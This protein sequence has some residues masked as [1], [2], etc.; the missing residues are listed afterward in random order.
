MEKILGTKICK[1]CTVKFPI[2]EKDRE[3]YELMQ[4][5]SPTLCY[6]CRTQRRLS[7]RN[8]RFLYHRKCELTGKEIISSFSLDKP[9]PVYEN[10]AWWSDEYDPVKYGRDFDFNRPFFEQFFLLRDSVPRLARQQQKPMWNSDYCNCA[11]QNKNCYLVFSTNRCEDCY[12]G[13][14]VN[15][16]KNCIDSKNTTRCELCYDCT[17]CYDCYDL[18]YSQDCVNCKSSNFLRDCI[19]CMD[20]FACSNLHNKQ[21][22]IFN[23]KKTKEE[24]ENFIKNTDLGS[25]KTVKEGKET[26]QKFLQ[27]MIVK[28]YHGSNIENS[29]GDYLWNCK[30]AFTSFECVDCEDV[31]YCVCIERAKSSMD[32]THWGVGT[33]RIYDCQACGYDLFNLRFCNLCWTGCSD[34]TYCDQ[35]FS[36]KNCFG[37]VGLKKNEY[38]ILN[39]QYTKKEYEELIPRIIGQMKRAHGASAQAER[40]SGSASLSEAELTNTNTWGEF[41]PS[42]KSCYAYNETLAQEHKPMTK[43]EVLQKGWIWKDKDPKE[44]LPQSFQVPDNIKDVAENITNEILGCEICG[45]NYKIIPQEFS[46]YKRQT[47][48]IPKKCSDCR[49]NDR[50]NLRTGRILYERKCQKC[51]AEI[52]T[53]YAPEATE[54]VYCEDCYLDYAV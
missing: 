52:K 15:D 29:L 23:Q 16:C 17:N 33:E 43:E 37:C 48:P 38:C 44:Y 11:S 1:N 22:H 36:S 54:I 45:K 20:C 42:S 53:T 10:D 24:Y 39:K 18:K 2:M 12:Y 27:D 30:N 3:F 8:E 49:H 47:V 5:S 13:S 7:Y 14:W 50:L 26:S 6:F 46:F 25:Y 41:F 40:R 35:C 34:L 51:V 32:H 28:Q 31:R 9:F 21:Y 19:G 4:V